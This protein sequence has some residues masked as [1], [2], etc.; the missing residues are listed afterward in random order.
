MFRKLGP[1]IAKRRTPE[2]QKKYQ[3]IGGKSPILQWTERQ[4]RL[5]CELLDKESPKTAPHKHYVCF[6]YVPPFT[7]DTF[8]Q[9]EKDG[10][11]HAVIFSQYP[12]YSCATSGSSF[13]AIY[14]HYSK[15]FL[16]IKNSHS[17]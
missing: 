15:R 17:S 9:I 8:N 12:Q 2:V 3:E 6:R 16:I 1:W 14:K 10:V 11:E 13:N 4:G 5:L 7:E